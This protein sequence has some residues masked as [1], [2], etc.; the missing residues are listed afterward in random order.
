[1]PMAYDD[2]VHTFSVQAKGE[3]HASKLE[4]GALCLSVK[5]L[6]RQARWHGRR[7]FALV[8]SMALMFAVR[9]GRSS[10][11]N[12]R[13]GS[14]VLA[15]HLLASEV[16]LHV[17]Y[18]PSRHNPSDEP[19]RGVVR[20]R[21]GRICPKTKGRHYQ[22][23]FV[24]HTHFLKRCYRHFVASGTMRAPRFPRAW[25][26]SCSSSRFGQPFRR[27]IESDCLH[28]LWKPYRRFVEKISLACTIAPSHYRWASCS[29]ES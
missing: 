16:Q 14:K 26:S 5:S 28:S 6:V 25:P 7:T 11:P 21:L 18:T 27:V 8:D 10:A 12:F 1:M 9:K 2:F 4:M 3:Q 20:A 13:F 24:K 29:Q 19:S 15:A 23:S 17:G 22:H